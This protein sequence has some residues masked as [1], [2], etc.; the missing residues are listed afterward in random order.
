M[1]TCA[2]G[3]KVLFDRKYRPLLRRDSQFRVEMMRGDEWIE[4]TEQVWF[5]DDSCSPRV[6]ADIRR[7]CEEILVRWTLLLWDP[8][9]PSAPS[10]GKKGSR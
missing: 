7:E 8:Q 5:Y 9:R 1:W 6:D 3:S 10:P 4:W 2:D